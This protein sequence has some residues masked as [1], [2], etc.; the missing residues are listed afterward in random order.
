VGCGAIEPAPLTW[1]LDMNT[2]IL[3]G[4]VL[5]IAFAISPAVAADMPT[6]APAVV[7]PP[8]PQWT[9]FN[10]G[11]SLG[12]RWADIQGTTLS[13]GPLPPPFPETA[14]QS[15]DSATFRVGG[16]LGY[17]WQFNPN[18][19]VGVEGD[20]AWGNGSKHVDALQGITLPTNTGNFSEVKHTWDAGLRARLG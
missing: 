8:A 18:W 3:A 12:G 2:K 13:F 9:G 15:Y 6:K 10:V 4:A 16:Y 20:F 7:A 17:D 5:A 19:L 1:G 11:L 14:S